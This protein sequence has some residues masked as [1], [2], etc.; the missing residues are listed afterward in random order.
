MTLLIL[1]LG[2]DTSPELLY[3]LRSWEANLDLPGGLELLTV[4]G[5]PE[6]LDS[7]I[8]V[9]G[10]R[11]LMP[12]AGVLGNVRLG[13]A[14]ALAAGHTEAV[15][16]NDD[17]FCMKPTTAI[18]TVRRAESLA[19]QIAA[20]PAN[21]TV[22][23][24]Q[25]L[26]RT[27]EWLADEGHTDPH[28]YEVHRPFAIDTAAMVSALDRLSDEMA[29]PTPQWR[30]V[31]GVLNAVEARPVPDALLSVADLTDRWI[32]TDSRDWWKHGSTLINM[33]STP[34]RWEVATTT[35]GLNGRD[36]RDLRSMGRFFGSGPLSNPLGR[37]R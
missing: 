6:W 22:W 13:A 24:T 9:P 34:S 35:G 29:A 19:D 2:V 4:G 1:P 18:D 23:W 28:S 12:A 21:G 10:T 11:H 15:V 33:F 14:A 16:M 37:N 20:L 25:S 8:H 26:I 32:S 31:Y 36:S 3:A 7:D 17:F 27:K 30:T 5:K